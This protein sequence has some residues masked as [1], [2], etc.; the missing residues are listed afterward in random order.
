MDKDRNFLLSTLDEGG[1]AMKKTTVPHY[2]CGGAYGAEH[3]WNEPMNW[4][5]RRVPGWFDEV[6]ISGSFTLF[7]CFPFINDFVTDIALLR[8]MEDG[9]LWVGKDGKLSIDGL[10][11]QQVGIYNFGLIYIEGE[12]TVHRTNAVSIENCGLIFNKGSLAIDKKETNGILQ[13]GEGK[14]DNFG[15]LLFI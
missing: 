7:N 5:N 15:E 8:I 11:K 4:Y 3:E 12:L 6:I 9:Q 14:F 2:W 13:S 10:S 1:R